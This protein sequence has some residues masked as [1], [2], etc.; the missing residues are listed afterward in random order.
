MS[1]VIICRVGD[2]FGLIGRQNGNGIDLNRNFPDQ[3]NKQEG[4]PEPETHAVMTWSREIPFVLSANLHGG[5]LVSFSSLLPCS[6]HVMT[7]RQLSF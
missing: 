5:S 3:Y 2:K 4:L 6:D 7:G 1:D